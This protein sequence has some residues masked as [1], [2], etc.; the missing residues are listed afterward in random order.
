MSFS[1]LSLG[2]VRIYHRMGIVQTTLTCVLVLLTLSTFSCLSSK[3]KSIDREKKAKK[4]TEAKVDQ[5]PTDVDALKKAPKAPKEKA[6]P[7]VCTFDD[8]CKTYLRCIDSKCT[9]PPAISGVTKETTPTAII[10]KADGSSETFKVEL[11]ISVKQMT[12][13]LMYRKTMREDWGMLFIYGDVR[14][15]SFWMKNTLIPLDMLFMDEK[16][17]IVGIV[18]GAEPMTK[19][20]RGVEIPSKYVLELVAGQTKALGIKPGDRMS[21]TQVE[22]WQDIEK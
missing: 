8:E 15:R 3:T 11:A 18:E 10:R 22:A 16:G 6:S 7:A 9:I 12:R 5:K 13:G 4:E 1:N 20:A 21:L 2:L 19:Q 14:I 17:F